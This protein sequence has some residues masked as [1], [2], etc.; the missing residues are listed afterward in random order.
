[1]GKRNRQRKNEK[2]LQSEGVLISEEEHQ[3]YIAFCALREKLFETVEELDEAW[4]DHCK[5]LYEELQIDLS[6]VDSTVDDLVTRLVDLAR[7]IKYVKEKRKKKNKFCV[8]LNGGIGNSFVKKHAEPII[9]RPKKFKKS[10]VSFE[11]IPFSDSVPMFFQSFFP[12]NTDE[13]KKEKCKH[14]NPVPCIVCNYEDITVE[15]LVC[16]KHG[17][18]NPCMI[19][20]GFLDLV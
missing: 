10:Q 19:C 5:T 2:A 4:D 6:V 8:P 17:N 11:L 14:D 16:A 3:R 1:M 13:F 7:N 18:V 15:D 9:I 12:V 20:E